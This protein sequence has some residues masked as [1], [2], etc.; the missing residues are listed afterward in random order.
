MKWETIGKWVATLL[1]IML[2]AWFGRWLFTVQESLAQPAPTPP[3]KV[4]II[5]ITQ[6]PPPAQVPPVIAP[7]PMPSYLADRYEIC[8][9]LESAFPFA[10]RNI[11]LYRDVYSLPAEGIATGAPNSFTVTVSRDAWGSL[12]VTIRD[13]WGRTDTLSA[14]HQSRATRVEMY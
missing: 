9:V 13:R 10:S 8:S 1:A 6:S 12:Q 2:I 3:Q 14:D 4:E 11:Y 5:N 7:T